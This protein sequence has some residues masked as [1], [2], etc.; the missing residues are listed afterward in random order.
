MV[1]SDALDDTDVSK[2]E[3]VIGDT[4]NV[5][6]ARLNLAR[7]RLA[8]A[9]ANLFANSVAKIGVTRLPGSS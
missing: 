2:V 9:S 7:A 5:D 6:E 4:T 3:G 1:K 8:Q